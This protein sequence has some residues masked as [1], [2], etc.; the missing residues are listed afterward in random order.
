MRQTRVSTPIQRPTMPGERSNAPTSAISVSTFRPR[1]T[2]AVGILVIPALVFLA[3]IVIILSVGAAGPT[4]T[5][6]LGIGAGMA[7]GWITC[8]FLFARVLLMT[9][10]V[11]GEGLIASYPWGGKQAIRW[12]IVDRADR[13]MGILRLRSSDGISLLIL[14]SGLTEGQQ[15][16]RQIILR[17]SSSVLSEPLQRELAILGG[18]V[19]AAQAQQPT[20]PQLGISPVW[21]L[22]AG[23][24]ALGGAA[25]A[26]WGSVQQ[27]LGLLAPGAIVGLVG[28]FLLLILRQTV[29]LTEA[30]ITITRTLG[31]PKTMGWSEVQL[32]EQLPLEMVLALRGEKRVVF[33]GPFFMTSLRRDLLRNAF[34]DRLIDQGISVYQRWWIW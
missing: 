6:L 32:I 17:V 18:N 34:H 33:L 20:F 1:G 26:T 4:A 7:L 25:L 29:I 27:N 9:I 16:L 15:L 31:G 14:E 13:Q 28:V 23:A 3:L 12:Q 30:G 24:L 22:A 19:S 21:S 2:L 5:I 8:V 11:S 10:H